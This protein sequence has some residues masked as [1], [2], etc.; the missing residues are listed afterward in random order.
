MNP[1]VL[2]RWRLKWAEHAPETMDLGWLSRGSLRGVSVRVRPLEQRIYPHRLDNV[3]RMYLPGC[4]SATWIDSAQ[5]VHARDAELWVR[6]D[7]MALVPNDEDRA[8]WECVL[9]CSMPWRETLI[10]TG[11]EMYVYDCGTVG[12]KTRIIHDTPKCLFTKV[13]FSG[14]TVF[15]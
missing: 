14:F 7:E 10:G 9:E 13:G 8:R 12:R 6:F 2:G 11:C 15:D 4:G 1:N 5:I 3:M